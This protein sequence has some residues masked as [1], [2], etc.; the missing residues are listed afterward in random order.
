MDLSFPYKEGRVVVSK[1]VGEKGRGERWREIG[2]AR[3]SD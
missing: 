3:V 2:S 1:R